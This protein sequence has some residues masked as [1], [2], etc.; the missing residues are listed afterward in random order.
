MDFFKRKKNIES[1]IEEKER[2]EKEYTQKTE[3]VKNFRKVN[4]TI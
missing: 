1:L 3:L 4:R 2:L